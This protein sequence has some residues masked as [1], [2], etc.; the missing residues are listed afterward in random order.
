ML[1]YNRSAMLDLCRSTVS[2]TADRDHECGVNPEKMYSANQA[3]EGIEFAYD[4]EAAKGYGKAHQEHDTDEWRHVNKPPTVLR[5][6]LATETDPS[7][8]TA[9][10]L[11]MRRWG[12]KSEA[13]IAAVAA[14]MDRG[15][16]K[17]ARM[18]ENLRE[19]ATGN[20]RDTH[21]GVRGTMS[22]DKP[23]TG[24]VGEGGGFLDLGIF[25]FEWLMRSMRSD[26]LPVEDGWY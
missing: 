12:C 19:A 15:E 2:T 8:R 1:T 9:I 16:P 25:D 24:A 10:K 13:E 6:M 14:P 17:V 20:D 26:P 4:P 7:E 18:V 11:A 22:V 5:R 3:I 21:V 23:Q